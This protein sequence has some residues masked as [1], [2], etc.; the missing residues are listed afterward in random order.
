M[1]DNVDIHCKSKLYILIIIFTSD[2]TDYLERKQLWMREDLMNKQLV[3]I[4]SPRNFA[5]LFDALVVHEF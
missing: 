4:T 3:L 1:Q 2:W 5:G